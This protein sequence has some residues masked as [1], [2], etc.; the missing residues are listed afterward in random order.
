MFIVFAFFVGAILF[1]IIG[2]AAFS[3]ESSDAV[4]IG[5]I[6]FLM[7]FI[8]IILAGFSMYNL[9]QRNLIQSCSTEIV[10]TMVEGE[11]HASITAP[12]K[13]GKIIISDLC[14]GT[15]AE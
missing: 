11:I 15:Q 6:S 12:L 3:E 2:C 14:K 8:L 10:G 7:A 5:I 13:N 9:G 4:G 1:A